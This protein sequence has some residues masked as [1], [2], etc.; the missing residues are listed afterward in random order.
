MERVNFYVDGFN[1]YFGL[2][3]MKRID[4]DWRKFYWLDYVKFFQHFIGGNQTLQ[5]VIY[6]AAPPPP[7]PP[8]I[9]YQGR[10]RQSILF[11]ANQLLNPNQF[12]V[13]MGKFYKKM[14]TCKVCKAKYTAYEEKDTDVNIATRLIGDC[15]LDNVDTLVLVT[16]DSDLVPPLK[17]IRQHYPNKNIRVYFPPANFSVGLEEFMKSCKKPIVRLERSKVKFFNSIMPD[18]VTAS[19]KTLT[20]PAKWKT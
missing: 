16:A 18:T 17:F 7:E 1:Y 8:P 3:D 14:L 15:T 2:K 20:I 10:K 6:F 13:V 9:G 5:K 11:R 4:S 12:E 19:G